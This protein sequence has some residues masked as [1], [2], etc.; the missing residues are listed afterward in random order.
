MQEYITF[1]IEDFRLKSPIYYPKTL[2]SIIF[3]STH[4]INS[5]QLTVPARTTIYWQ[6]SLLQWPWLLQLQTCVTQ[7][8]GTFKKD[9]CLTTLHCIGNF[10]VYGMLCLAF[11]IVRWNTASTHTAQSVAPWCEKKC[12]VYYRNMTNKSYTKKA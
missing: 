2:C 7:F 5:V 4:S 10:P 3:L 1:A 8:T 12:L 6:L 9:V 11:F